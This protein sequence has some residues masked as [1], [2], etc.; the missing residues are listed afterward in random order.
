M[1]EV[2][3]IIRPLR[4]NQLRNAL[5]SIPEFFSLVVCKGEGFST[6]IGQQHQTVREELTDF[7]DKILVTALVNDEMVNI[8]VD[9]IVRECQTGLPH[10]GVVWVVPVETAYRIHDKGVL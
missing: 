9:I 7:T 2:R 5:H 8:I 3:A 6:A 4:L 10:D 1:K